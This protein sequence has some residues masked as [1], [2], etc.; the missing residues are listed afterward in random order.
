MGY[1]APE[2]RDGDNPTLAEFLGTFLNLHPKDLTGISQIFMK[3]E[4][5]QF[6][7]IWAHSETGGV[8]QV[9]CC[10]CLVQR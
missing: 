3:L 2:T 8:T 5:G 1:P 10:A 7:F 4:T 9:S 6:Q